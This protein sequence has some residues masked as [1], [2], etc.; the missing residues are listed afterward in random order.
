M[1]DSERW[2]EVMMT[3]RRNQLRSFLTMLGVSWG[4]FMLVMMLGMGNGLRNAIMSGF[5]GFASNCCFIWTMPTTKPYAGFQRGRQFTFDNA[6]IQLIR[7][8]VPGIRI[9]SPQLQLGGW[10]G[11]NNVNYKSKTAA[12]SIYGAEPEVLGVEAVRLLQGRFLNHA[13][14][15]EERKV[16]A[17]GKQVVE[18]LF[19]KED[20]L[21]KHIRINGVYFQVIGTMEKK[22]SAEMGDN[23]EAKIYVPFTT[24][25][26]AFNSINMVHW[27]SIVGEDGE[28][29]DRIQKEVKLLMARKHRVDP[30]DDNA[31][32]SFNLAEIYTTM[33]MLFWFIAFVAWV[34]GVLSLLAGVI[35]IGNIM[36][37]SIKER[38]KEIGI[39]RSIGATPRSITS[40]I[41]FEALVLIFIGGYIGLL[42]GIGLIENLW[43][44]ETIFD[45]TI[46]GQFIRDPGVTL[47]VAIAAFTVLAFGGLFAGFLPARR[48]LAI[49][50]V[51]AL[52]AE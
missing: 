47:S 30:T 19:G 1:F 31:F 14:L 46:E 25:Q 34:V 11:G 20:P 28:D 33:N 9:C 37:I 16:C 8:Q 52:R 24:F 45:I 42:A 3:L 43:I 5:E 23:P 10:Q 44:V 22:S 51:D 38:T 49:K 17:I 26:K 32:G 21:G 39:R 4:I 48:A 29:V 12:F 50:A 36:L 6:D 27:F 40:Q 15:N 13:D 7:D 18:R 41:T 2:N 35:G